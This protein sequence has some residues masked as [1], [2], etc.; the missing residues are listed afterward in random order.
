M[1]IERDKAVKRIAAGEARFD[2]FTTDSDDVLCWIVTDYIL[3]RVDHVEVA[4][5]EL[6]VGCVNCGTLVMPEDDSAGCGCHCPDC[7]AAL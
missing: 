6:L 4:D 1:I 2:G 7:K 3:D 5:D